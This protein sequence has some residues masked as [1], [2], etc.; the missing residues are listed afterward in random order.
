MNR[1]G[2]NKRATCEIEKIVTLL[3]LEEWRPVPPLECKGVNITMN[4]FFNHFPKLVFLTS[5]GLF[6]T[7]LF[8]DGFYWASSPDRAYPG[9]QLLL[10]GW[11]AVP[12]GGAAWFANPALGLGW[13]LLA[14]RRPLQ[15]AGLASLGLAFMLSFLLVSEVTSMYASTS[16]GVAGYGIGYWLWVASAATLLLA[17]L[18]LAM[19]TEFLKQASEGQL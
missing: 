16:S 5:I 11:S 3:R 19:P 1:A 14:L 4:W 2:A 15:S 12:H 13:T 7:S 9:W 10:L 17:S 18:V 8:C 6:G